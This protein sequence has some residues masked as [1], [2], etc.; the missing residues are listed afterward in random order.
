LLW[1][2]REGDIALD[3]L[4][5]DDRNARH[6]RWLGRIALDQKGALLGGE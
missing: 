4:P 6:V 1:V 2:N 5:A 3:M